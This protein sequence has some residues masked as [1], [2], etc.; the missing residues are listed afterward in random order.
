MKTYYI[1]TNINLI[2]HEFLEKEHIKKHHIYSFKSNL[3]YNTQ[4]LFYYQKV[5]SKRALDSA[6]IKFKAHNGI[7]IIDAQIDIKKNNKELLMI[8]KRIKKGMV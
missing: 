4:G 5:I 6:L 3:H 1:L 2:I 7:Y 8:K